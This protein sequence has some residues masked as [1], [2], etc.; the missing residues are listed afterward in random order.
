VSKPPAVVMNMF[1]TGLGI[2]RSLGEHGIPVIGLSSDRRIYGNFS[3]YSKTV[4][5]PDSRKEP[6]ALAEFLI[7]MGKTLEQR[8]VIF[9]TRDD[10]VIFLDRYRRQLEPYFAVTV[11]ESSVLTVCLNKWETYRSACEAGIATPKC[12]LIE[13][14]PG[15]DRLLPEIAYPCVL[16]PVAAHQWRQNANWELVGGRKA[17]KISSPGELL[18][19]YA[20]VA[21]ANQQAL[22]Q[23]LIPGDDRSLVIA[24]CYMDRQAK[25]VAGFNTQKLVQCPEGFGTGCIVRALDRPELFAP[26]R[27][28]LEHIGFTGIAEV[29][30]KWDEARQVYQLIEINPRPWD[31]HRLGATC[32]TDL[33]Y[34]AYCDHAGLPVPPVVKKPAERKWVAEDAFL[35]ESLRLFWRRDPKWRDLFRFAQGKRIYAIWSWRDPLPMAAY[36]FPRLIPQVLAMG[37]T[38]FRRALEGAAGSYGPKTVPAPAELGRRGK[39]D[40]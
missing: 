16:K 20:L 22:I 39:S 1:Y 6:E 11:P 37:W 2:A 9:P 17:I 25:W 3:R 13:D 31:Q 36:L 18:E 35:F 5:C 19:E 38:A 26:A 21:R 28:L 32:G 4:F 14:Q 8:A 40:A 33:V 29:E 24:A 30:F 15:L 7:A 34:L 10:D 12:W 23:E 27:R